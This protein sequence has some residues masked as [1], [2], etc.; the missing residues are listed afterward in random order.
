MAADKLIQIIIQQKFNVINDSFY[1]LEDLKCRVIYIFGRIYQD[2][3]NLVDF[4][5]IN[6]FQG[7]IFYMN[8]I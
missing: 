2:P 1:T 3:L 4:R 7:K 8:I 6:D 5:R